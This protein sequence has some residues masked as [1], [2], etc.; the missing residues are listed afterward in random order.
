MD[1]EVVIG[2]IVSFWCDGDG[3]GVF[4]DIFFEYGEVYYSVFWIVVDVF[5]IVF[6][7]LVWVYYLFEGDVLF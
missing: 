3:D 6:D 5:F 2:F 4:E 7:F 1:D